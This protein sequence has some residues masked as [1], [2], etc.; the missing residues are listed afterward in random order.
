MKILLAI[1]R[2]QCSEEAV[3]EV[4]RRPWPAGSELRIISAV[5][6]E[7]PQAAEPLFAIIS[8]REKLLEIERE[9]ARS[10]VDRAAKTVSEGDGG[11]ELQITLEVIEGSAKHVILAEA[12]RWG[13]DLIVL[14]SHGYGA[15]GRFFLGSVSHAVV[16]HAP[17][18]VQIV[19]GRRAEN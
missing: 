10:L 13:A 15:V 19:R 1:D 17:C 6:A 5:R 3:R 9:N 18:S 7:F 12:E 14:G 16:T 11:R 8:E 4:A 2:S